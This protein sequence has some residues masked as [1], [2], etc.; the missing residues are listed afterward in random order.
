MEDG[1]FID[2]LSASTRQALNSDGVTVPDEE[3]ESCA[4]LM[5]CNI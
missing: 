4:E 2:D 3:I 1:N 5:S